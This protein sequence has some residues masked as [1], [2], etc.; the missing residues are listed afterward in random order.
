MCIDHPQAVFLMF[1]TGNY[2]LNIRK[3]FLPWSYNCM[4][5]MELHVTVCP[6]KT[7]KNKLNNKYNS[8]F[9]LSQQS[10]MISASVLSATLFNLKLNRI[11]FIPQ[12]SK[13]EA[14]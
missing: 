8:I 3:L 12:G 9:S 13:G 11:S 5:I 10:E 2:I 1:T 6:E 14:E 7:V 4:K